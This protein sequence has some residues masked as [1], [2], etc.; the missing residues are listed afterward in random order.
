MMT[1]RIHREISLK[2]LRIKL[3]VSKFCCNFLGLNIQESTSRD[4]KEE[5]YTKRHA[6]DELRQGI[7]DA[8]KAKIHNNMEIK[9]LD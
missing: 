1:V 7:A 5:Q 6:T 8:V 9:M 3:E 4:E 2:N